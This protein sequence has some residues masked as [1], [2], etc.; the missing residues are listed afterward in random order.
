MCPMELKRALTVR[1][2]C[3]SGFV[4]GCWLDNESLDEPLGR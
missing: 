2:N 1:G 3:D 4:S